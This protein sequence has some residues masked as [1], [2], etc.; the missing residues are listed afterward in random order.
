MLKLALTALLTAAAT[1]AALAAGGLG[2]SAP[3]ALNMKLNEV[4][5]LKSDN[6]H[7]QALTKSQVACGANSLPS[8]TQV[9]FTPH[10]LVVLQ[11][12]KSGKKAKAIFATKR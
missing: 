2:A 7:C 5:Y 6:F 3:P 9:Y 4:I 10:K 8:S 11:F 1:V 12:D